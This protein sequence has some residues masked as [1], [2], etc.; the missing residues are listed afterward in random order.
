MSNHVSI[1]GQSRKVQSVRAGSLS[2]NLIV[3]DLRGS[4][5]A[6][7]VT[8]QTGNAKSRL[9]SKEDVERAAE[10]K[11]TFKAIELHERLSKKKNN[12]YPNMSL[13]QHVN[14]DATL[15]QRAILRKEIDK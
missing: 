15:K 4:F 9:K 12:R 3:N 11:E 1:D 14:L 7:A 6:Y 10:A 2:N 5:D 8:I 13:K